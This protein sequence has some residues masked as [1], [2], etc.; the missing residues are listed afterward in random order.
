MKTVVPVTPFPRRRSSSPWT[1]PAIVG[2]GSLF[3]LLAALA[4]DGGWDVLSWGLLAVPL[5]LVAR[6]LVRR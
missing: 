2:A 4:L 3:A 6:A 1:L 5:G